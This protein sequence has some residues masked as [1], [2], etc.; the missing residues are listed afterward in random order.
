[1]SIAGRDNTKLSIFLG[2]TIDMG[3]SHNWQEDTIKLIESFRP[4]QYNIFNPRRLD[5]DSS[6]EQSFESPQFYQQVNW[7]LDALETAD[8]VLIYFEADS[9]SPISLLELGLMTANADKV[10]VVCE[11]GYFRKGNVEIICNRY[12]IQMYENIREWVRKL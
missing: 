3:N 1:M 10:C 9:Q 7:E 4:K 8:Y 2:G 6:W 12:D 5:W 11:D